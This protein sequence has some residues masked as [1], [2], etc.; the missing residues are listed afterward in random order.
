M[1][2]PLIKGERVDKGFERRAYTANGTRPVSLT[3]ILFVIDVSA[4][5][6]GLVFSGAGIL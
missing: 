6:L 3:F 1:N 5:N 4:T 2:E